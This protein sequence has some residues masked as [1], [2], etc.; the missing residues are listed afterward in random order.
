ML[1]I[2]IMPLVAGLYLTY[3]DVSAA[4]RNSIGDSFQEEAREIAHKVEMVIKGEMVEVQRLTASTD[5]RYAIKNKGEGRGDLNDYI[6]K[7]KSYDEKE[8]H[9]LIIVKKGNYV[10]DNENR[11]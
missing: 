3:L 9:S 10:P 4:L 7:F 1:I 2:S 6:S 5:V 8:V 11:K